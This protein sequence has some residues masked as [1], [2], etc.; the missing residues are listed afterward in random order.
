[1]KLDDKYMLRCIELAKN[2][3]GNVSPNPLVGC[4][5]V[6]NNKI[7]G[8]GYHQKYGENH[9][10]VNALNQ[11]KDKS[12]LKDSTLYVTLEPCSHHGKTP[13]CVDVILKHH[14]PI[15]IIGCKDPFARVNGS[16]IKQLENKGVDVKIGLLEKKCQ[17][18]NQRFFTFHQKKRPYIILKWAKTKDSYIDRIRLTDSTGINWITQPETK[19]LTHKWRAEEQALLVGYKTV[20]NDD[21]NLTVRKVIGNN[22]IRFIIDAELNCP[23]DAKIF[24]KKS[25]TIIFN[26]SRDEKRGHIEFV[27]F[28]NDVIDTI[29]R[30]CIKEGILSVM[31]EGGKRTIQTFIDQDLWDEARVLTGD[32]YFSNGLK[33]P[34][35][36]QLPSYESSFGSDLITIYK[37]D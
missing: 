25:K 29:N 5:I 4:V 28:N 27:K 15:V 18:L 32:I 3:L 34:E 8:E 16:G 19:L 26:K 13:P 22:P 6:Y 33:A 37:N 14:I 21:P 9:A 35:I 10:E 1:M 23:S 24:N 2:G 7:I 17:Q 12:I 11:V 31:I 36:N 30:Y 20:L